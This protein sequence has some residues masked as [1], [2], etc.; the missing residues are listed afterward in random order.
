VQVESG[1]VG[2]GFNESTLSNY[3]SDEFVISPQ[4]G[5]KK[6][7]VVLAES[8]HHAVLVVRNVS[9]NSTSQGTIFAVNIISVT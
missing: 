3:V 2:F 8:M 1:A 7:R 6:I 4:D 5:R 9:S